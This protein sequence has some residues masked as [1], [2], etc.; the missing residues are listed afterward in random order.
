MCVCVF[1]ESELL[2]SQDC[3]AVKRILRN[4]GRDYWP[5]VIRDSPRAV[6]RFSFRSVLG[7]SHFFHLLLM[8]W[9][10]RTMIQSRR[11]SGKMAD[12][13]VAG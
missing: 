1:R 13:L 10:E 9:C 7:L 11:R 3:A 4:A 8:F 5:I 6:V 2:D 12:G